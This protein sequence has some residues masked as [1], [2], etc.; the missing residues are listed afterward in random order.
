MTDNTPN[1]GMHL[2]PIV[3]PKKDYSGYWKY[4]TLLLIVVL[5]AGGGFY[6]GSLQKDDGDVTI[7]D[8]IE[9]LIPPTPDD[10]PWYGSEN[11]DV[12]I[13]EFS[14]YEC[15]FCGRFYTE[16]LPS[17]KQNYVDAGK[18]A[19]IFRD[20]PLQQIHPTALPAAIAAQC[21]YRESNNNNEVY[22]EYH[23]KL[24]ENSNNLTNK[25]LVQWASD[26]GYNITSCLEN[27]ETFEEVQKDV[28]DGINGGV[29]GTPGFFIINRDG[30]VVKI[31]GAQ[32]YSVFEQA[33]EQQLA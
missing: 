3:T 26:L 23:D 6:F 9:D 24:F 28:Q 18:V 10:D 12:V 17:I 13:I 19:M 29:T 22:F 16:T 31:D 32:P 1:A 15:P 20:F 25:N 5:V 30:G 14:D 8:D 21:V 33:I 7:P 11:A 27:D 4:A 2:R